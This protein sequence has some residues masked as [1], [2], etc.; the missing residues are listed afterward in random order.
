MDAMDVLVKITVSQ[1]DYRFY[2][3]AAKHID[4]CTPE[5]LMSDALAAFTDMVMG[6]AHQ[7]GSSRDGNSSTSKSR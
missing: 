5:K 2:S 7:A 3:G 1:E 4:G 6:K